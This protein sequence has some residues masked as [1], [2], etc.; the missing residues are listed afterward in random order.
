[1]LAQNN[2]YFKEA[3]ETIYQLTQEEQIRQQCLVHED[4]NRTMNG[5][6]NNF[7]AQKHKLLIPVPL[8]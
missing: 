3:S 6:E 5:I 7:A 1:M 4:Y 2:N 8:A